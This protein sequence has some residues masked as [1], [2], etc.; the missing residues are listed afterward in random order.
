MH[1]SLAHRPA[2]ASAGSV[3]AVLPSPGTVATAATPENPIR[4]KPDRPKHIIV[5]AAR[6]SPKQMT[7]AGRRTSDAKMLRSPP[8]LLKM[9]ISNASQPNICSVYRGTSTCSVAGDDMIQRVPHCLDLY[10]RQSICE[11]LLR[12]FFQ[13]MYG[14]AGRKVIDREDCRYQSWDDGILSRL[15]KQLPHAPWVAFP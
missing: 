13:S 2:P 15:S 3:S 7:R 4:T 5:I 1:A 6:R 11:R 14:C 10:K 12:F 8:T 9:P